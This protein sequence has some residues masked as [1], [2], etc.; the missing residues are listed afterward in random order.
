MHQ[1]CGGRPPSTPRESSR[2]PLLPAVQARTMHADA[3]LDWT[4]LV[5]ITSEFQM[6]R[7]KAIYDW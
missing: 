2:F 5:I 1:N 6:A 3:R 7:T 4:Q